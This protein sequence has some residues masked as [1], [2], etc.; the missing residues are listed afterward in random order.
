MPETLLNHRYRL[1]HVLG[2]GGF[3]RTYVAEDIQQA[4]N[5][6]CVIK[7]LKPASQDPVFLDVARRLFFNEVE[8][9]RRLGGHDRI[10]ALLQDFE[11]DNQF[12]LVQEYVEGLPLSEE[13]VALKQ[14]TEVEVIVLLR[15]VLE[16]LEF[17]HQHNIVHRDI[18]PSNLMRRQHDHRIVLIDFGAVKEMQTQLLQGTGQ[19]N[20]TVGIATQGYGPSEQLAG[21]PRYNSD[22]YA[23]GITA[24]QALTGLHPSQLPTHPTTGEVI[25]RDRAVV[26][27]WL[28]RILNQMVRYHFNQRFQSAAEVLQALDQTALVD[29]PTLGTD[30]TLLPFTQMDTLANEGAHP[31]EIIDIPTKPR[32]RRR[33]AVLM[34]GSVSLMA[35]AIVTGARNLGWLQPM[36]IAAYDWNMRSKPEPEPDPRLLVVGITEADIQAQKRFPLS[37]EAIAATIAQLQRHQPR[38][39]GLDIFRDIP[40]PPGRSQLLTALKASNIVTITNLG[41]P[42]TPAPPGIPSDRVGFNDVV[43]DADSVVRRNLMFAD[44][45]TT[46]YHSF[47]LRLAEMYLAKKG[48]QLQPSPGDRTVV[49]L[50]A[51]PFPPLSKNAGG[52]QN[53]DDQGYQVMLNYRGRTVAQQVSLSQVL[54]GQVPPEQI[55]DRIVLIGTTAANAKDLFLTPF[56]STETENSRLPG[57]LIHAQMVSQFLNAGLDGKS[58]I[59]YWSNKIEIVWIG[60]WAVLAG[61]IAWFAVRRPVWVLIGEVGLIAIVVLVGIS[62]FSYQ[63]WIPIIPPIFAI[64]LAGGGI[65]AYRM[66]RFDG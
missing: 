17:V 41:T 6:K 43:L 7:Q 54:K 15:D 27:P 42:I 16:I 29:A 22:I 53:L 55:K 28:A 51:V 39:I 10:P 56:S 20:L 23:L 48:I 40:Q 5:P 12:Y 60:G 64:I 26:T 31:S 62:V 37:D 4:G 50:G 63:G 45:N 44:L 46:T 33:V 21:K 1:L 38:A 52:Y 58:P 2:S 66:A 14:L 47:S 61:A 19:T 65:A 8:I 11:E 9:L 30:E 24:I 57:V 34:I 35:I 59:W 49:Q 18:K 13:L 32:H 3:G 25:W 36:E